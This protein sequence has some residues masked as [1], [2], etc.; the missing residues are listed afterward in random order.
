V[1]EIEKTPKRIVEE[2]DSQVMQTALIVTGE[3]PWGDHDG[4]EDRK[5]DNGLSRS[6]ELSL[7]QQE[8]D[9]GRKHDQEREKGLC[10]ERN[11]K[12]HQKG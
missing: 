5:Q 6:T 8:Q 9:D 2:N 11:R 3:N 7:K 1:R 12:R 10:V 4:C